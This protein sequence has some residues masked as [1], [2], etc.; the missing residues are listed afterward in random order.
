M[1]R[2]VPSSSL[3]HQASFPTGS[4][5]AAL[6]RGKPS[7]GSGQEDSKTQEHQYSHPID[8][9]WFAMIPENAIQTCAIPW[10]PRASPPLL[11]DGIHLSG[12]FLRLE[13]PVALLVLSVT[14]RICTF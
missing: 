4:K 9:L 5:L 7:G 13:N 11:R 1:V 12:I 8:Y 3:G 14:V 6:E 2:E 10:P